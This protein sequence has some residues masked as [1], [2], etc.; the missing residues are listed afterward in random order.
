MCANMDTNSF[1]ANC[2]ES[3]FKIG[4]CA[5][6]AIAIGF[7]VAMQCHVANKGANMCWVGV[8]CADI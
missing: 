2:G 5:N 6:V 4:F 1:V 8:R 7:I 3:H